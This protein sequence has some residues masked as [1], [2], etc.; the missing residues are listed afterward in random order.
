MKSSLS[1]WRAG[2]A[3]LLCESEFQFNRLHRF[4]FKLLK[5][6]KSEACDS[7]EKQAE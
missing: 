7:L 2:K 4:P 3:C 6:V 1:T 5:V